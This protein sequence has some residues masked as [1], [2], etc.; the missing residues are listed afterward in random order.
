M[1]PL[2]FELFLALRY[3]RPKRT[4]VS[5]ITV[6][7]IIGVMLGVAV[8]IIVISVMSGFG[9]QWRN[10]ILGFNAHMKILEP[11]RP[12]DGFRS[13]MQEVKKNP[14]VT[15]VAPFVMGKVPIESRPQQS[16]PLMDV[17]LMRGVLPG[18]E[19][20]VSVLPESVVEGKFDV[21]GNGVVVG[22][23]LARNMGLEIGSTLN[24]YSLQNV[25]RMKETR[26]SAEQEVVLPDEFEV[27]GIFDVGF[28]DYNALVIVVSLSNAQDLY[29]LGNSVHGLMVMLED[30]FRADGVRQELRK[31]LGPE[32]RIVTWMEENSEIFNALLSEKNMMFFLLF[33][34]MIVAAFGIVNSQIIFVIQKTREIGILKALGATGGQVSWL[35]LS[36]SVS[37]GVVGVAAGYG[38]AMLALAYRN[39]FLRLMNQWTG[40]DLLPASIYKIYSLPVLME[41]RDILLICGTAFITC[42]LAGLFPAWNAGRLKPVEALRHE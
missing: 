16:N 17:P 2:P 24:I 28:A 35:F 15:G 10:K 31:R 34:I 1:S 7:S 39:E 37:I 23:E 42:V 29:N 25:Q 26:G 22:S 4:F 6:I 32:F 12:M 20:T 30:P 41:P 38:L 21:S 11:G 18:A 27:T 5:V 9:E 13:L 19:E 40:I 8:L 33:F 14:A 3:L 36:Q